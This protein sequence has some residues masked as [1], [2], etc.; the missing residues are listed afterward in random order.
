MRKAYREDLLGVRPSGEHGEDAGAR[1]DVHHHLALEEVR[2]VVDGIAV[3]ERPHLV[4]EHL[5]K[6]GR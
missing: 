1:A 5:L 3:G 4:L 2:V 6:R